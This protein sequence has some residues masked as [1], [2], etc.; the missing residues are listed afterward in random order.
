MLFPG[1]AHE[2]AAVRVEQLGRASSK[3]VTLCPLCLAN[4]RRAAPAGMEISDIS[5]YLA[6][7]YCPAVDQVGLSPGRRDPGA[8]PPPEA[9]PRSSVETPVP[10]PTT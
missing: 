8:S 10:V 5:G 6:R 4:L 2:I 9:R 1:R 3:V 7:A